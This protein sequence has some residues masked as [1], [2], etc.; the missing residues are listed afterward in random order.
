VLI[1]FPAGSMRL[2]LLGRAVYL[3]FADDIFK[4]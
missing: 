3:R 4:K 2:R 1:F